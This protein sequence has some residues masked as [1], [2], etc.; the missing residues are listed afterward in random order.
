MK[1]ALLNLVTGK[2]NQT[3]DLIRWL[4]LLGFIQALA[5]QA[6]VVIWR[7][8]PFDLQAFG[9]GLGALL[10]TVGAALGMK[11]DTEPL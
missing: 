1:E 11:K 5:L 6:Y 7:G 9:V 10:V 8:Q 4:G 2:D 3:H